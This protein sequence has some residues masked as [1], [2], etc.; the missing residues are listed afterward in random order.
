MMAV[1]VEDLGYLLEERM[2]RE[3][4]GIWK[5]EGNQKEMEYGYLQCIRRKTPA[6]SCFQFL[7]CF[8]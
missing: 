5:R 7:P 6:F 8:G 3:C 4:E 1:A 2:K